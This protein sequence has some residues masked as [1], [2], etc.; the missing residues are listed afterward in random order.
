MSSEGVI[1]LG[2]IVAEGA[3]VEGALPALQLLVPYQGD[4]PGVASTADV[5]G[6]PLLFRQTWKPTQYHTR[7]RGGG[8]YFLVSTSSCHAL[9]FYP[10]FRGMGRNTEYSGSK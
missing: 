1:V 6:E 4:V 7:P 5:A 2:R 8:Y 10:R 3:V 9:V